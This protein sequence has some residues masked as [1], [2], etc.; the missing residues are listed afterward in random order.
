MKALDFL[1]QLR[2]KGH[3]FPVKVPPGMQV[4]NK[5]LERWLNDGAVEIN[6]VKPKAQ[7]EIS[8][9]I[10]SMVFFVSKPAKMITIR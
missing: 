9:P 10:E 2:D 7:D 3:C 6:G 8:K 1:K 4:S 5:Q